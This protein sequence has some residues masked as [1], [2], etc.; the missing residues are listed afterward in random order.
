MRRKVILVT[1]ATGKQGGAVLDALVNQKGEEFTIVGATRDITAPGAK[2]LGSK[3]YQIKLVEGNLD[4]V[5]TLFTRAQQL[6]GAP[7]WGVYSVQV[8]MGKGVT[9]EGEVKQ[10]KAL[11]DES[12]K[13][14]VKHFV[15]SSVERGGDEASWDNRTPIPHFQTK[16]DIE[17]HLRD[18]TAP[19]KAGENMGW[20]ILRPV[21]FMDNLAPGFPTKVFVTALHNWLGNKSMQWVATKDI[22][23]FAAKAFANPREW[24]RKAVGIAGDELNFDQMNQAF[25]IV[26]GEPAPVTYSVFGSALTLMVPELRTMICWFSRDGYHA[27][28][29]LRRVDHPQLLS[30][31]EWLDQERP[32]ES[33]E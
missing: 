31:I 23:V 3:G 11:I 12:I 25:K 29:N 9:S 20:T 32:F 26:T 28:I 19:G 5:A 27:N 6:A 4:D 22:G 15:Y 10:G 7:I 21:A 30:F 2:K 24:N 14:G 13:A 8:S 1:G 33:R 18:A 17:H 16:Y